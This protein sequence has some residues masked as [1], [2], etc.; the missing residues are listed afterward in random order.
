MGGLFTASVRAPIVGVVLTLELT[1]SYALALPLLATCLAAN[2][3]AQWLGGRPIYEQLLDRT[4][5]QAGLQR[6][7]AA[8]SHDTG[9]A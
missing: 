2:L 3:S 5:Q 6:R 8:A 1:G 9:L 7:P 4:L